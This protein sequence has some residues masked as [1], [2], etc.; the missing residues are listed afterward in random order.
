MSNS[1]GKIDM[2]TCTLCGLFYNFICNRAEKEWGDGLRGL[3][4][5]AARYALLNLQQS[6]PHVKNWRPQILL[7]LKCKENE[8]GNQLD[9]LRRQVS[10]VEGQFDANANAIEEPEFNISVQHPKAFAFVHQL[11]AG[12]GL[13][14]CS[15]VV[16]GDFVKNKKLAT[17]CKNVSIFKI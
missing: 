12:K 8:Q 17:A 16:P 2:F 10:D 15:T 1:K 6:P 14:V 4:M 11:K 7:L 3:S 9:E 13:V 5:S